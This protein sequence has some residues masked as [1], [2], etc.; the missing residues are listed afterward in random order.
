[1]SKQRKVLGRSLKNFPSSILAQEETSDSVVFTLASGLKAEFNMISIPHHD[2]KDQTWVRF[3]VNGRDQNALTMEEVGDIMRTI[4]H[5]QFFPAI[6]VKESD[7]FEILDGSRR[8]MAAIYQG[9]DLK[10]LYTEQKLS[11]DDAKQLAKDIQ[12]AKE[13]SLREVGLRL[14]LLKEHFKCDNKTLAKKEGLSES[15]VTRSL[16]AAA[17]P[18]D[19]VV[20]FPSQSALS[21]AD[22]KYLL[23]LSVQLQRLDIS[24]SSFCLDVK[25]NINQLDIDNEE[26]LKSQIVKVIKIQFALVSEKKQ[27]TKIVTE[28]LWDFDAKDCYA[29]KKTKGRSIS[30]E[31]NRIPKNLQS[32]ID[33]A[34]KY[35]LESELR[36]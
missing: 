16:Q 19:F 2:I 35:V 28:K 11:I 7:K 3:E 14:I 27:D 23:D 1:M 34:V 6:A 8:R 5:Q 36:Q 33:E 10:I 32:K 15:K 17:V 20:L 22:Y 13:H 9:V 29:R 25:D 24:I 4:K 21:Y 26:D 18:H 12:T 30:Y 31:F